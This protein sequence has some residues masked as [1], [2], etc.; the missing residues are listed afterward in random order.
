LSKHFGDVVKTAKALGVDRRD[1][2]KL[3]WHNPKILDAAAD[4]QELFIEHMWSEAVRGL[5]SR[6]ARVRQRAVDRLF[7]HPRAIDH[8]F[9]G[10]LSLFARA[11][12]PRGP[13]G[14]NIFVEA[15]R[16]RAAHDRELAAERDVE[17]AAEREREAAVKQALEQERVEVMV[18]RRPPVSP[19]APA[20]SL[21]PPGVRRPT[22]GRRWR[23]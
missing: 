8:P 6:S 10:G 13:R 15:E 21:W 9:A 12:R 2:R 17:R 20:L 14:P 3:I 19:V 11:P 18:E 16:A 1:L 23:R 7:A 22:R 5:D 4:R